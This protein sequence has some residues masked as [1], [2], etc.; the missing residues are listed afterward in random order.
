MSA[1]AHTLDLLKGRL[2]NLGPRLCE[3]FG[4]NLALSA[5]KLDALSPLKTLSR[6]YSITYAADGHT[7]IDSVEHVVSG[8]A[9]QIQVQDGRLACTVDTVEREAHV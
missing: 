1:D 3:G 4:R 2:V 6:G 5:A 7:V 9:I 8:D